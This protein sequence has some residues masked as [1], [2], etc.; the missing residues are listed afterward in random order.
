MTLELHNFIWEE[1]RL[2]QV[3]TQP[4]HIAGVLAVIQETMN[5]SDCEWEDVYS[6]YIR[7]RR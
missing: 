2:V 1:E 7:V 5:D 3:E 6:A 4:H